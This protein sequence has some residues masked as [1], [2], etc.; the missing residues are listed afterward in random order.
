M[1]T[2]KMTSDELREH[3]ITH[4]KANSWWLNDARGIPLSRVCGECI[5]AVEA[6]YKPEVLGKSG[7]YEDAVE[8]RIEEEDP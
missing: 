2:P 8:E 6:T 7:R 5:D 1:N 3:K 4:T